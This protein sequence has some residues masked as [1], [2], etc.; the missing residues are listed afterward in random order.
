MLLLTQSEEE[1]SRWKEVNALPSHM[2]S[3]LRQ[4]VSIGWYKLS[5]GNGISNRD[6]MCGRPFPHGQRFWALSPSGGG[7]MEIQKACLIYNVVTSSV[8]LRHNYTFHCGLTAV[9][10]EKIHQWTSCGTWLWSLRDGQNSA[11][12]WLKCPYLNS[13]SKL[14]ACHQHQRELV[15]WLPDLQSL[16]P[17]S[18]IGHR[19]PRN[20]YKPCNHNRYIA[21]IVFLHI[22]NTQLAGYNGFSEKNEWKTSTR[23]AR[24]PN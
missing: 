20:S 12:W 9:I 2:T 21:I 17:F 11:G 22:D 7:D 14:V 13:I 3:R 16:S 19:G 1:S 6:C 24:S 10:G 4:Q 23:K 8:C 15:Q 5:N 18:D